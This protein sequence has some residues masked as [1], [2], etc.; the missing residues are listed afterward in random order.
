METFVLIPY[1]QWSVQQQRQKRPSDNSP[2]EVL[3]SPPQGKVAALD[4]AQRFY[5]HVPV[6]LGNSDQTQRQGQPQT[7][8]SSPSASTPPPAYYDA[9]IVELKS[10]LGNNKTVE[11]R[12]SKVILDA[13]LKEPR[14]GLSVSGTIIID[15]QDTELPIKDFLVNLQKKSNALQSIYNTI[16]KLL[17]VP[18]TFVKNENARATSSG[19]WETFK[20]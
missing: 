17:K 20:W 19:N 10:A 16:L 3:T 7:S 1:T 15:N 6:N 4:V 2:N 5:S 11:L 8:T 12:N 9:L 14:L 18:L 13:F